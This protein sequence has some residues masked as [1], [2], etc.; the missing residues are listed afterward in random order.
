[1]TVRYA[2][3]VHSSAVLAAYRNTSIHPIEMSAVSIGV[4]SRRHRA[5]TLRGLTTGTWVVGLWATVGP[6]PASWVTP[7][8]L[9]RRVGIHSA[10]R[11]AV[12]I[13]L[14]DT[15][16]PCAGTCVLGSAWSK[17]RS[18]AAAQWAIA[19]APALG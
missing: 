18:T 3:R 2:Q 15:G 9:K 12:G 11:P 1:V 13:L 5:P 4:A 10:R 14:A 8:G 19:L 16:K 17:R 6:K 7:K